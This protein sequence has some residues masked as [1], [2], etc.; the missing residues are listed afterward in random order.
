MHFAVTYNKD[1]LSSY[2]SKG[3]VGNFAE[4]C[5]NKKRLVPG[6]WFNACYVL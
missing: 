1:I 6:N 5:T 3:G 2:A 4:S